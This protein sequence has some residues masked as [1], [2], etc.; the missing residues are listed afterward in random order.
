MRTRE[1]LLNVGY[2]TGAVTKISEMIGY[3]L[4][5][6]LPL[7]LPINIDTIE[8]LGLSEERLRLQPAVAN[9]SYDEVVGAM[10]MD[11]TNLFGYA[12]VR[13]KVVGHKGAVDFQ[14]ANNEWNLYLLLPSG[15]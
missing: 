11:L 6:D 7:F 8:R 15:Q 12:R 3:V 9:T 4:P 13:Y 2:D 5:D 14:F 10:R 1:G